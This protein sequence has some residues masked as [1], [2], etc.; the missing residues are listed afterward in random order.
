MNTN[1]Y[2]ETLVFLHVLRSKELSLQFK[3]VYFSN[4]KFKELF[5]IIQ[6]FIKEYQQEPTEEQVNM[7]IQRA[8][9]A[10]TFSPD[11]IHSI[12]ENKQHLASY[13]AS[14]LDETAKNLGEYNNFIYSLNK[15]VTYTQLERSTLNIED[16]HKFV[17]QAKSIFTTNA[18]FTINESAGHDFMD[19]AEHRLTLVNHKSTGYK[20]LN[21]AF[22]GGYAPKTLIVLM[23]QPKAGK[24]LWLSNLAAM[25]F[26]SGLNVCYITLELSAGKVIQ[27][28]GANI[29][30]IPISEYGNYVN[31]QNLMQQKLREVYT[32]PRCL[33][34]PGT[35]VVE[36]YPT[37][38][39]T[40]YD[41]ERFV[42]HSEEL[43]STPDKEFKYDIIYVDYLNIMADARH[44]NSADTYIKIKGICEDLRAFAMRSNKCVVSVTQ[45]NRSAMDSSDMN[46]AS[47]SE[48]SGTAA[49]ADA[50][51]GIIRPPLARQRGEYFLKN[52]ALRDSAHTDE[53]KRFLFSGDYMRITETDDPVIQEGIDLPAE[54]NVAA[55]INKTG[56]G[57][58]SRKNNN[59][60]QPTVQQAPP[61]P[62]YAPAPPV[63]AP[64]LGATEIN[65]KQNDLFAM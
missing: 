49:T 29:L 32:D 19:A 51:I 12:W 13:A 48:S 26:F 1:T 60:T 10:D 3:P 59:Q 39:A 65:I 52:I 33:S 25:A 46:M 27:R 16:A 4:D 21:D 45:T 56:N 18:N 34:V 15:V 5:N 24:S 50:L 41:I 35:L 31:D 7:L 64:S 9:Q 6:P 30:N 17:E 37:S 62:Q 54:Y 14:W 11:I 61:Q 63:N 28:I 23:A 42:L 20:F 8:G 38:T 58:W 43:R 57:G 40:A 36:E 44:G 55:N 2:I 47:L 22:G 53:K